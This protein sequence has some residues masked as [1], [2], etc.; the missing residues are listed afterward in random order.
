M[1]LYVNG[2]LSSTSLTILTIKLSIKDLPFLGLTTTIPEL[3][4]IFTVNVIVQTE[5]I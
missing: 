5:G 4:G 1:Y 2:V 3:G